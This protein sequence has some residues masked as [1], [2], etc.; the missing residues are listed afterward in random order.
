MLRTPRVNAQGRLSS[1]AASRADALRAADPSTIDFGDRCFDDWSALR[2]HVATTVAAGLTIPEPLE[3]VVVVRPAEWGRRLFDE[4]DQKL[5]WVLHDEAGDAIRLEVPYTDLD[6]QAIER[7]EDLE[8]SREKTWG[9][10]GFARGRGTEVVLAPISLFRNPS[11]DRSPVVH[12]HFDELE[13][14]R[15]LKLAARKLRRIRAQIV[16]RYVPSVDD[17]EPDEP[18]PVEG[19]V[20][21]RVEQVEG[22]ILEMAEGGRYTLDERRR[23]EL[24]QLGDDLE[25]AGLGSLARAMRHVGAAEGD[26]AAR[27]LRGPVRMPAPPA[28]DP[29]GGAGGM[30]VRRTL[31]L[32]LACLVACADSPTAGGPAPCPATDHPITRLVGPTEIE[33]DFGRPEAVPTLTGVLHGIAED[34]PADAVSGIRLAAWRGRGEHVHR[35]ATFVAN[36][37]LVVSDDVR[38]DGSPATDWAAYEAQVREIARVHGPSVLYDIWNEPDNPFFWPWWPGIL[39]GGAADTDEYLESFRRAHD[40]IRDELGDG[41]LISGPSYT[42]LSERLIGSFMDYCLEHGLRVQV[43]SVHVLYHPDGSFPDV[44]RTLARLRA[45]YIDDP[46]YEA[47]GVQEIHVNEYGAPKQYGRP[48]SMLALI[49]TMEEA[50]V[51]QAMR[52]TWGPASQFTTDLQGYLAFAG[53]ASPAVDVDCSLCDSY[54]ADLLTPDLRPRPIWWAYKHYADGSSSRVEAHS[55][56]DELV[57]IASRGSSDLEGGQLLIAAYDREPR[58]GREPVGVRLGNVRHV[59]GVSPATRRVTVRLERIPYDD[60]RSLELAT[61]VAECPITIEPNDEVLFSVEPPEAYG[62]HVLS[63]RG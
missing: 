4:L 36:P 2:R 27:L 30:T 58:G 8:A 9:I 5:V 7:L 1:S 25:A 62:V 16:Q 14:K 56:L 17:L 26:A 59:R 28:G 35:A 19:P 18:E 24:A 49:R 63:I 60:A 21:P 13:K 38:F 40:V 54:L 61:P 10:L 50:G 39:F 32:I 48:G 23:R 37:V 3:E 15:R 53:L 11:G 52:A 55:T 41:A 6:R 34:T 29:P 46:T 51:S 57:P 20:D 44:G 43:L 12:L 31:P 45:R 33:V 47:V 42:L 22:L